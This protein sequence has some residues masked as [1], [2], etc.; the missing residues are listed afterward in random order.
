[1][2]NRL[3]L[4]AIAL[5]IP[6]LLG[7]Q[8]WQSARYARVENEL[9]T[10]EKSQVEWLE[11]NKRLIAGMAILGSSERIEKI[12]VHNLGMHKIKPES[13]LQVRIAP[14]GRGLDG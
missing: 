2:K 8:A 12:A 14:S 4:Y 1:M 6:A 13:V 5:S 3:F 11:S 10:L 7:L 9:R